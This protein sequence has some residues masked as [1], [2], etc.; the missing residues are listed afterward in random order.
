MTTLHGAREDTMITWSAVKLKMIEFLNAKLPINYLEHQ[1]SQNK[2][3]NHVFKAFKG[4]VHSPVKNT[5][6]LS[7]YHIT[8]RKEAASSDGREASWPR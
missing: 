4:E 1:F 6:D 3:K 7:S 5:Y 8:V 2:K